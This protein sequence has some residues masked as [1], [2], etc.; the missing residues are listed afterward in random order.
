[1]EQHLYQYL[2]VE[3]VVVEAPV[4]KLLMVDLEEMG[5]QVIWGTSLRVLEARAAKEVSTDIINTLW[6]AATVEA[7]A[8]E[9]LA[10]VVVALYNI[11]FSEVEVEAEEAGDALQGWAVK[12]TN[13][14]VTQ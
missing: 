11:R 10:T 8:T 12:Q 7:P 3:E 4:E 1:V 9:F 14:T 13:C 6:D 2:L 5:V